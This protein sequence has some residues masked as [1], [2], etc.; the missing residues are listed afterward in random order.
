M[1][2]RRGHGVRRELRA[3]LVGEGM[4]C[5]LRW[6]EGVGR[7]MELELGRVLDRGMVVWVW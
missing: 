5:L 6:V 2:R 1:R 3:V 4:L 7:G